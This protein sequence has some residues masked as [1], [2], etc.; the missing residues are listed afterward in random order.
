MNRASL[1]YAASMLPRYRVKSPVKSGATRRACSA[2]SATTTSRSTGS[3]GL[4]ADRMRRVWVGRS[5]RDRYDLHR[6]AKCDR[7]ETLGDRFRLVAL[8]AVLGATERGEN[9]RVVGERDPAFVIEAERAERLNRV[10]NE[11]LGLGQ[12][13]ALHRPDA[14][15]LGQERAPARVAGAL[16][17]SLDALD[18]WLIVD[19]PARRGDDP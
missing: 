15:R 13:A 1:I 4:G 7:S 8:L 12:L 17:D 9:A 3:G 18:E 2:N 11:L 5:D 19:P 6:V 14:G 10:E 16:D